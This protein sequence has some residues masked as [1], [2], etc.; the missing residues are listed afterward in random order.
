MV[1]M[2]TDGRK[3]VNTR[4]DKFNRRT[5]CC[6]IGECKEVGNKGGFGGECVG[7]SGGGRWVD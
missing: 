7:M 5:I 6:A 3:F 2:V 1:T 4:R